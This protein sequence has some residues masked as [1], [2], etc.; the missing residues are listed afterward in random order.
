MLPHPLDP[1]FITDDRSYLQVKHFV[2]CE[3]VEDFLVLLRRC[4]QFSV[5]LDIYSIDPVLPG[6]LAL[7]A[8]LLM[9]ALAKK[10]GSSIFTK[11][12]TVRVRGIETSEGCYET[13]RFSISSA[14]RN[15]FT[16]V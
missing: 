16:R 13:W 10:L 8:A 4:H 2:A 11:K 1:R 15:D 6:Q 3:E 5:W 14:Y 12:I 9:E 7:K